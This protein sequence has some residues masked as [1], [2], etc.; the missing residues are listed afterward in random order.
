M[1]PAAPR[2]AVSLADV[3]ESCLAAVAG[4]PGG[5]M[6]PEVD[7]AIVVLVDGLGDNALRARSGHARTLATAPARALPSGFPTTTAVALTSLATGTLPGEHGVVGYTALVPDQ[8]RVLNQLTGWGPEMVPESWQPVPTV[9]ER[10]RAAGLAAVAIGPERYRES[11]FSR[12]VLRGADYRGARTVEDRIQ[13]ARQWLASSGPGIAYV[14]IPELDV[15]AH[16]RG[17]RS[18]EWTAALE[19]VDAGIR[20]LASALGPRDGMIVTGDHGVLDVEHGDHVLVDETPG[21]LS[22]VRHLAGEPRCLQLHVEPGVDPAEVLARWADHEG[23]RAWVA[24]RAEVVASGWWGEVGPAAAA[25]M[26]DVFV[27]AREPIAYY[28]SRTAGSSRGMTGQ[29]GA[30]SDDELLVPLI[31]FGAFAASV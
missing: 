30:L 14:Y 15:A 21:L 7:H 1:L 31:G 10:T 12:A 19:A 29:H 3:L 28:D 22:G 8:D 23:D 17:G 16:A 2:D 18:S 20:E 25:R 13:A 4:T 11:G 24:S 9:F 5:V 27:A 6:L 26:G